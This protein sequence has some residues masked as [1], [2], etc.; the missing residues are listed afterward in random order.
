M[1]SISM[2][3]QNLAKIHH[4]FPK[5]V[6]GNENVKDGQMDG[7]MPGLMDGQPQNSI[8]PILCMG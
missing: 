5:I 8:P 1:S 7:Q 3:M 6:S 4:S 2:H